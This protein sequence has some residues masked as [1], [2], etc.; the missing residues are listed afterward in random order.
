MLAR[1]VSPQIPIHLSTQ[2]NTTNYEAARF[3][4]SLGVSRINAARELSLEE[5]KAIIQK[6]NVEVEAFIHGSM[7]ISYSGRCLL[8]S[9][10]AGRDSNR[11]LCAHPCRWQYHVVEEKRP[12]Q[13]FPV[14]E[15]QHGTYVF[16]A[17]DLCLLPRLPELIESGIAAFKIEGRMKSVHYL[18]AT[19]KVYRQALDQYLEDP[20]AFMVQPGWISEL[21]RT[22]RR[23]ISTGFYFKEAPETLQ[24]YQ[25]EAQPEQQQ[26]LGKILRQTGP[27]R[28]LMAVR[29]KIFKG[30]AVE[31]LRPQGP[32]LA[33]RLQELI[34]PDGELLEFAQPSSTV[35]VLFS[36]AYASHDIVRRGLCHAQ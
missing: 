33:D 36:R 3:W 2:A 32:P 9:V 27:Q 23:G 15:D 6:T 11:G 16:N 21:T 13:Y 31:V 4:A 20:A 28:Y 18:A 1:K 30:E 10:M 22:S 8:S 17:K 26:F 35:E 24:N 19:V 7:C 12:G 29:N 14:T 34:S 5:I 25:N